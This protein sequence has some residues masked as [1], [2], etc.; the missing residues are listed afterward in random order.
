[1]TNRLPLTGERLNEIQRLVATYC[2]H[3][4]TYDV[5]LGR[6]FNTLLTLGGIDRL[7]VGMQVWPVQLARELIN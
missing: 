1:M 2:V 6:D 4:G 3:W 5:P 7:H